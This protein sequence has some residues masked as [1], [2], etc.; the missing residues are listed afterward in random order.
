M[1]PLF[2]N[3]GGSC[4]FKY[5]LLSIVKKLEVVDFSF[6]IAACVILTSISFYGSNESK[7]NNSNI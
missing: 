4:S 2:T 5:F 7:L 1:F 3:Q 6:S